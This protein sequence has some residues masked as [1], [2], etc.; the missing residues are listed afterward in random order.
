ML[1]YCVQVELFMYWA[2]HRGI[3]RFNRNNRNISIK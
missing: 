3:L 2:M 1:K